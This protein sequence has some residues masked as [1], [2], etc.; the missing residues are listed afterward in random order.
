[1]TTL[2]APAPQASV[3]SN[4]GEK[5]IN[6]FQLGCLFVIKSSY[7]SCRIGNE[8][9]DFHLS[10]HEVESKAIASFGT[11][12]LIDPHKGRKVFQ[13]IEKKARHQL[14]KYS[15]PF[16]AANAHFVPWE[17]APELIDKL[18]GLKAEFDQ[19]VE[20]FL[21]Q[22][23]QLRAEWQFEH[24]DVPD[25]AYPAAAELRKKFSFGWHT[26]KVAGAA[27]AMAVDDI[28]A[29][30]ASQQLRDEQLVQMKQN[31]RAE[32]QQFASDYVMAF[33]Q[34]VAE[35]CDQVIDAGGKVHGKTLQA[36]RRKIEHFHAMNIFN[37]ADT[38]AQLN[39]L[40]NQIF[41]LTG[42]TLK[43]QPDLA[44]KLSEACAVLKQEL[45]DPNSRVINHRPTEAA[46]SAG[47]IIIT[48]GTG[49]AMLPRLRLAVSLSP[50]QLEITQCPIM[51]NARPASRTARP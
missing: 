39:E 41:G 46:G 5:P 12:E 18:Q 20:D 11:K 49:G 6:L 36:I 2:T 17:H 1:M 42:E 16:P 45:L 25:A 35:F 24:S 14:A 31:L 10:P 47:L 28:Q 15:K 27:S 21:L 51:L 40:K 30:L 4:N 38:A 29:E 37:D 3:A 19:A 32:C 43:E 44:E 7:W 23:P 13:Q 50:E 22:Y 8:P 9:Q 26:F 34:E 33:R 48:V